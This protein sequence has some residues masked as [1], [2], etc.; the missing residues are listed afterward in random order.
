MT[1]AVVFDCPHCG[2]AVEVTND[3]VEALCNYCGRLTPV[4]P[5]LRLA[6]AL[7]RAR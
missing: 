2:A 1:E 6:R 7:C 5:E 4:P 3:A